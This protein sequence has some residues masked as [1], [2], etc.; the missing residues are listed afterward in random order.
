MSNKANA[1]AIAGGA[2]AVTLIDTLVSRNIL[3]AEDAR[4]IVSAALS[5]VSAHASVERMDDAHDAVLVLR[6]VSARFA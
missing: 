6:T 3:S 5:R 2:I 1:L 4:S